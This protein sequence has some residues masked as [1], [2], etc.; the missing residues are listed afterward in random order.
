MIK[1]VMKA[2]EPDTINMTMQV[3]MTVKEWKELR[4]LMGD[5]GEY[6]ST[7]STFSRAVRDLIDHAQQHFCSLDAS[8]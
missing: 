1:S 3:T 4:K 5:D 6:W 7:A 8:E 2:S